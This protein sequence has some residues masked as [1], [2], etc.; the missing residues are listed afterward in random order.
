MHLTCTCIDTNSHHST[1][2]CRGSLCSAGRRA[3]THLTCECMQAAATQPVLVVAA[4]C[5]P[6]EQLPRRLTAFFGS[7]S[8][9]CSII[10]ADA[11]LES[12]ES[13][14]KGACSLL[15]AEPAAQS[16][17]PAA[18]SAAMDAVINELIQQP[19]SSPGG[20]QTQLSRRA[21]V[22]DA[23]IEA[24]AALCATVSAHF[25]AAVNDQ[26]GSLGCAEG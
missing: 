12:T 13:S 21:D 26:Q 18:P 1:K 15:Q 25:G 24:G 8:V 5:T 6:A 7:D 4:V 22:N 9:P 14:Q 19:D 3:A 11:A 20:R 17:A 16:S 2:P 23:D 10:S